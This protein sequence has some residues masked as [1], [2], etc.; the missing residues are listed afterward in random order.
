MI[1]FCKYVKEIYLLGRGELFQTFVD[2]AQIILKAP[3]TKVLSYGQ[4]RI[5]LVVISSKFPFDSSLDDIIDDILLSTQYL[6]E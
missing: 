4:Y 3:P 6:G 5:L 1:F 2:R